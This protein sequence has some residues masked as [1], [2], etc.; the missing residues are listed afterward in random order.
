MTLS[1]KQLAERIGAKIIG[2][3][4]AHVAR[5]AAIEHAEPDEVT[6]LAN[7]KYLQFLETTNAAAVVIDARMPCPD[8]V[9]RLVADDPYFAFRNAKVELHGFRRHPEP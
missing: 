5:C 4:S 8:H 3:G 1:L 9:V 2:D 6:F 7:K